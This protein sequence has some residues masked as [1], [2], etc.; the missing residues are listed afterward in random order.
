MKILIAPD[1]FKGSLAADE[2]AQALRD[3]WLSARPEDE[4]DCLPLSDGGEGFA[5]I[6]RPF[7]A[8]EK[9]VRV[10]GPVGRAVEADYFQS[11]HTVFLE[12]ATACGLSL[13]P[14]AMRN[15][16]R[17]STRGVG[18]I[19]CVLGER[20]VLDVFAG[21]GGSGTNDGGFGMAT[22]LGYRFLDKLGQDLLAHPLEL[23]KLEQIVAP[24]RRTW[25]AVT[26]AAD[27]TNP[28]LGSKGC[29]RTYGFQKGMQEA[30]VNAFEEALGCL[31]DTVQRD[32]GK[33]AVQMPGAGAS[34]G[35]GYGLAVFCDAEVVPGFDLV[36]NLIGL[37]QI[38]AESDLV[39][40]GEGSLDSQS[41]SGKAPVSLARLAATKG[42]PVLCVAGRIDSALDWKACFS[43][44]VSTTDCAGSPDASMADPTRWLQEAAR[45]LGK[46]S[47]FPKI[48]PERS[49]QTP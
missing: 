5:R 41:L 21:L 47:D 37:P 42:K 27:V 45:R 46:S 9:R 22:A 48:V 10:T 38:V 2:V 8:E 39:I 11:G 25:P 20:G 1:K 44:I 23:K 16:L 4:V 12:T 40:T 7:D 30:D 3:G 35:L 15:P 17:T 19:L 31:A 28:L 43:K 6:C 13:V 14:E 32:L 49:I 33:S 24:E 36:S 26:A 29:T 34:G 18:E